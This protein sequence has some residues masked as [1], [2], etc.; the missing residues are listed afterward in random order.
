MGV[1]VIRRIPAVVMLVLATIVISLPARAE[2]TVGRFQGMVDRGE[3]LLVAYYLHSFVQAAGAMQADYVQNGRQKPLSCF[4]N[5]PPASAKDIHDD[6]LRELQ[7]RAEFRKPDT[8][9]APIL[10][11]VLQRRYPCQ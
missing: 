7:M 6:L 1:P 9:L 11:E 2:M 4:A 5:N 8:P 3:T 10:V